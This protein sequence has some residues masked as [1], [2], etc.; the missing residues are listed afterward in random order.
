MQNK[1][2]K[3]KT[4]TKPNPTYL[5]KQYA[6]DEVATMVAELS[7]IDRNIANFFFANFDSKKITTVDQVLELATT[8]YLGEEPMLAKELTYDDLSIA[9]GSYMSNY[10]TPQLL[11]KE[12]IH[13]AWS[14]SSNKISVR[15]DRGFTLNIVAAYTV[16][17]EERSATI[18]TIDVTVSTFKGN[19]HVI[20]T[21][22]SLGYEKVERAVKEKKEA[23]TD[24]TD[25]V[26]ETK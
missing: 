7:L 2:Q 8:L 25:G 9:V 10:F 24:E 22:V 6:G 20:G 23:P 4:V 15:S 21:A 26:E 5:K 12:N 1:V 17:K 19:P 14:I 18:D 11:R 13:S 3:Q 16:N